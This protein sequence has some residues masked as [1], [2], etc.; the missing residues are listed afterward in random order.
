MQTNDRP[1]TP[2]FRT[3]ILPTTGPENILESGS[4]P[5]AA[6]DAR[7]PTP[8]FD[9]A[10]LAILVDVAAAALFRHAPLEP[11]QIWIGV[12]VGK[13]AIGVDRAIPVEPSDATAAI[14]VFP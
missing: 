3:R 5:A 6:I 1:P 14:S 7:V 8:V 11:R 9:L 4:N 2:R 13:A 10:G 12:A